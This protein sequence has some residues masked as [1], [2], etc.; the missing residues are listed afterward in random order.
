MMVS[1]SVILSA[2][3]DLIATDHGHEILRYAQDDSGAVSRTAS[4]NLRNL[5]NL[6]TPL[7]ILC[8]Q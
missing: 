4:R 1:L 3:K 7:Q 2:A 8:R 5:R 6:P